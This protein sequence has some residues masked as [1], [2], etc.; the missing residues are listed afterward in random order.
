MSKRYKDANV[1]HIPEKIRDVLRNN[2]E[3]IGINL[4]EG[5]LDRQLSKGLL[6]T[7]ITGSG[8]THCLYA[9]KSVV[10]N[11]DEF[12][13]VSEV[14]NWVDFLFELK[15][16]MGKTEG[17]RHIISEITNKRYCFI[18]DL[19][20]ERDTE[21]G[22]EMLYLVINRIYNKK[23]IL[24]LTTNLSVEELATKYGERIIDRLSDICEIVEMPST[25]YRS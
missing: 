22:Q 21:W 8:K 7:G 1:D 16:K 11:Y 14:E 4:P 3:A 2:T 13:S 23:N 18:D 10:A 17:M 19:G 9:I 24:F 15:E 25:N 12:E 6:I 5:R 20:A